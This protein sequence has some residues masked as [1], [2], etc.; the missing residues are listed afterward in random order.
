M[1]TLFTDPLIDPLL[2]LCSRHMKSSYM[3]NKKVGETPLSAL[4]RLRAKKHIDEGVPMAYAGRLDPM[5]SGKLLIL[6]G[7]ECKKQTEYHG[8]DK[9]Y[10]VKILF[11]V[12]TDTGDILGIPEILPSLS[13]INI[14]TLRTTL[15]SFIGPYTSPYP[16][17]SSKTVLGTPLF[18]H[19]LQGTITDI[20]IPLQKGIIQ[21]ITL[22]RI[23]SIQGNTLSRHVLRTINRLPRVVE[24][25]K[26][27]G[28]DFR[29]ESIIPLWENIG[30]D[31]PHTRFPIITI[32]VKTSSGV[33]MRTL[34]EDIGKKLGMYSLAFSIH[35]TKIF[36]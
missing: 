32:R 2:V 23:T 3:V 10:V 33:Y 19:A 27:A 5:A 17:Y 12:R 26:E 7:D 31:Y 4:T 16:A 18:L 9:E 14:H 20:E 13:R 24:S 6:V 29:R 25:S 30:K 8:K 22:S 11:G 1:V 15:A 21:S 28:R 34:A 36:V 35:R